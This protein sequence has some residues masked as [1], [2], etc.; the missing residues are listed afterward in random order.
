MAAEIF[1]KHTS[2]SITGQTTLE[3]RNAGMSSCKRQ[4]SVYNK[5]RLR[6]WLKTATDSET[7][8]RRCGFCLCQMDK[9]VLPGGFCRSKTAEG[10]R[11]RYQGC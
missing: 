3:T 2:M 5:E 11:K 9:S 4:K 6:Y 10:F 1:L 7:S 8:E